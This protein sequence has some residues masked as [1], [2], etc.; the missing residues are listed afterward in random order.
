MRELRA[1]LL[2]PGT[3]AVVI[4]ALIVAFAGADIEPSTAALGIVVAAGVLRLT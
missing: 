4:P 1:I 3:V 2:L